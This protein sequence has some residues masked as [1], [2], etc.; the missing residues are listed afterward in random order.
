MHPTIDR[1][2]KAWTRR[3]VEREGPT[4]LEAEE[5]LKMVLERIG[6]S[7]LFAKIQHNAHL[8][9]MPYQEALQQVV[10]YIK[11]WGLPPRWSLRE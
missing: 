8:E 3:E 11:R 1:L 10:R 7:V 6:A 9:P 2:I 5:E 4:A